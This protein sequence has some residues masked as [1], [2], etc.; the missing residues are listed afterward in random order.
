MTQIPATPTKQPLKL[1]IEFN[2]LVLSNSF[3][4]LGGGVL[5]PI[6]AIYAMHLGADL[7]RVGELA[8]SFT[9]MGAIGGILVAK[10]SDKARVWLLLLS[11]VLNLILSICYL[12]VDSHLQLYVLQGGFGLA[13][14][15]NTPAMTD[16]LTKHMGDNDKTFCWQIYRIGGALAATAAALIGGY[17][18]HHLGFDIIFYFM[19]F[20]SVLALLCASYY[21]FR[22]PKPARNTL[23]ALSE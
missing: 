19:I 2:L 18:S 1:T 10:A 20:F 12:F 21:V 3:L 14:A 6:F 11:Y 9:L 17:A 8:A 5:A 16:H 13:S 23:E 15:I 22:H 4:R 7:R